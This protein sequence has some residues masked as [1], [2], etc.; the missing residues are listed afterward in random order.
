MSV[1]SID[2]VHI[3]PPESFPIA[4]LSKSSLALYERCPAAWKAR[5]I[6]KRSEPSSGAMTR[7]KAIGAALSQHFAR[8]IETGQGMS[9][10]EL[11]DEY[12]D[13]WSERTEREEV[14]WGEEA[15]GELK[16]RGARML[17]VYH[18]DIAP[19]V[20]P[21]AVERE[22][23]L[24][25][26]DCPFALTGYI[27][28]E[29]AAGAVVDFKATSYKWAQAKADGEFEPTIYLAARRAEGD[30]AERF[31]YHLL[32]A[33]KAPQALVVASR[34]SERQ[35]DLMSYR[36]FSIARSIEWRWLND[37]W[38]GAGPDSAWLCR[39]CGHR[40]GCAWRRA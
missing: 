10:E 23:E 9:R 35:L 6:D 40:D 16:D 25:W 19:T 8:Q 32:V 2:R 38:Q 34:R 24:S 12:S 20:E 39:R 30:P 21:V 3:D 1:L 28:L 17:A 7:G 11:L 4:H 33:T 22:F 5:Y 36:V 26:P 18:R 27:D 14:Q 31:D 37:C 15:P 29:T 13:D